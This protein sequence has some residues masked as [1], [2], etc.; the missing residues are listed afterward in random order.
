MCGRG[1]ERRSVGELERSVNGE[2]KVWSV[3]RGCVEVRKG[4]GKR[5]GCSRWMGRGRYRE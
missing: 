3:H 4:V 2:G 5:G 1:V